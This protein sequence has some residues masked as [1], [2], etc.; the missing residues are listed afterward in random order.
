M[1]I[2]NFGDLSEYV[3]NQDEVLK[4]LESYDF[5]MK[6]NGMKNIDG[7][8]YYNYLFIITNTKTGV[9]HEFDYSE[10]TGF[11]KLDDD[12]KLDKIISALGS[13]VSDFCCYYMDFDEF[14][15]VFGYGKEEVDKV[16]KIWKD[17]KYNNGMLLDLM[18]EDDIEVL[19]DNIQ[20]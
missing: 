12:N 6:Y 4:I 18:N 20:L 14:V 9:D 13:V 7:L 1:K 16:R 2:E 11:D 15:D 5:D 10:G 8:S 3:E 17:I 19:R